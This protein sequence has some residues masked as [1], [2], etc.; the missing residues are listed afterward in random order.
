[1]RALVWGLLLLVLAGGAWV[2]LKDREP[3]PPGLAGT[4]V[5]VSDRDGVDSL[6]ARRL[7]A[8]SDRRLTFLSEPVREPSVSPDGR[9]VAFSMGGRIGLVGL[10]TGD[11]RILTLGVDW[12]DA[13]PSWRPDGK[14]L[15]VASRRPGEANADIHLLAPVDAQAGQADRRP[16]TLTPGLDETSP[17]FGPDGSYVVFARQDNLMRTDLADGRTR[18]LTGGFRKMREPRFLPSGR[19]L[20]LWSQEKEYGIDVMDG[21]G[22]NRETLWQGSVSYRTIAPSPDGRFLAATYTFDLRFHPADALKLRHTE[23][24]RLLDDRGRP[25]ATL[26]RSWRHANHSPEW[27]R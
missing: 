20:A 6:Y 15:L 11:V 26:A 7:P 23:E 24:V 9:T 18:R 3:L 1:M 16:L 13:S 22:K 27:A 12:R 19:L 25:L 2:A 14:A 10:R 8:G 21:D 5:Y 4:L 17:V